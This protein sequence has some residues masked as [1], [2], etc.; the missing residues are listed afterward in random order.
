MAE[1]LGV[2][3]RTARAMVDRGVAKGTLGMD[4]DGRIWPRAD[5]PE[6]VRFEAPEEEGEEKAEV[7]VYKT[8]LDGLVV[9]FQTLDKTRRAQYAARCLAMP[10]PFVAALRRLDS[11]DRAERAWAYLKKCEYWDQAKADAM[12][13]GL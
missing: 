8:G 13:G 2:P 6:P 1:D 7:V 4:E 5:G 12:G 9:Y 11:G 10:E 3:V